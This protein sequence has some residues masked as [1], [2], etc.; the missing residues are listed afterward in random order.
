MSTPRDVLIDIVAHYGEPLLA[1][2]LRCEGLLKDYCGGNRRE[3]FVLVSCLRAGIIDQ[4]RRQTGPSMKL[5]CARLALKLEQNL[6][7]SGDVAKWAVE[8]WAVALGMLKPEHA[9][10]SISKILERGD[11]AGLD[12]AAGAAG[13]AEAAAVAAPEAPVEAAPEAAAPETTAPGAEEPAPAVP[14]TSPPAVEQPVEFIASEPDSDWDEPDWS[15]SVTIQ[16]FPDGSGQKPGLREAVRDA[17]ENACLV[18]APGLYR[19]SLVIKRNVWIRAEGEAPTL[20]SLSAA[21]VFSIEGA[22]LRLDR[23][24]IRGQGGKDKKTQAAVEIKSGR[25]I[26]SDCDVT[27]DSSTVLEVRGEKAEV[28][29]RRCHLHDGK[30]GGV[31]F[32]EGG[33]GYLEEC[34]LYQNKLSQVVIGKDCAP[35]LFGCKISHAQMAGVYVSEGGEGIIENCDIWGNAVGGVQCRRGGNP[36]LRYCRI[37]G[38]QRYGVLVAEQGAG[39][40]EHCQIFENAQM[41]VTLS[42]QSEPRF[43]SCRV[44]DNNGPGVEFSEQ[45]KGELLDCEIF[46][47]NGANVLVED[48]SKVALYRCVIHD[49]QEE[50]LVVSEKSEGLFEACEISANARPG[51]LL[52]ESGRAEF[53]RCV[54]HH[55]RDCGLTATKE[56]VGEFVDCEFTHHSG[57]AVLIGERAEVRLE[58]CHVREN[59]AAGVHA[60]DASPVL[61]DCVIEKNGGAGFTSTHNASPRMTDGEI[62]E[63]TGGLLINSQGK[64]RWERVQFFDNRGDTVLVGEGGRPTMHLC[65]IEGALGAGM[66]FQSQGLGL[67]EDVDIFG[68]VGPGVEI[69]AGGNP[70]LKRVKVMLG[71]GPGFVAKADST[72]RAESCD[73]T[74]N[75]GGDWQIDPAARFVRV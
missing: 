28:S 19:E 31:L 30:A 8:S 22:C 18:L 71:K 53:Q 27:S 3:I 74:E 33:T 70:S 42:Q 67:I 14:E 65:Q 15:E 50:G 6:A 29:V 58:R 62:A 2:P 37:S 38:N 12:G 64:G 48:K 32:A 17:A 23:L 47:N 52:I 69:E 24:I 13:I 57:A 43:S 45:A 51:V 59:R 26:M 20:E 63:N 60:D 5:I 9:T 55:G 35:V 56:A 61:Q 66:R 21:G 44:F 7:I 36:R 73:A 41:G 54:L 40:F 16:V 68:S 1:S 11:R 46:A 25:L 34:A 72:G 39:L 49:G 4:M 75:A 10:L